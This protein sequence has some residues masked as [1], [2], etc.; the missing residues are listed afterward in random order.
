[1]SFDIVDV[2]KTE[3]CCDFIVHVFMQLVS[4]LWN[5]DDIQYRLLTPLNEV[6]GL[7]NRFC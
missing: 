1:M 4:E 6:L 3:R 7:G 5:I 2:P